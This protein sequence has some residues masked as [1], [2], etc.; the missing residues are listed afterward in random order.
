MFFRVCTKRTT[1]AVYAPTQWCSPPKYTSCKH[2]RSYMSIDGKCLHAFIFLFACRN[3]MCVFHFLSFNCTAQIRAIARHRSAQLSV[4][5][6]SR[7]TALQRARKCGVSDLSRFLCGHMCTSS[8]M[9]IGDE[10]S[11]PCCESCQACVHLSRRRTAMQN[12]S[13]HDTTQWLFVVCVCVCFSAS[14]CQ[15]VCVVIFHAIW[16]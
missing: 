6:S 4:L 2:R 3:L 7:S 10:Y 5:V 13:N 11:R 9:A 14:V 8:Q 1:H 15:C 12:V 16:L